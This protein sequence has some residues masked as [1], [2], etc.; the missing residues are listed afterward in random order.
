MF[1]KQGEGVGA[2]VMEKFSVF[3]NAELLKRPL[4]DIMSYMGKDLVELKM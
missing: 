2:K 3:A 1:H 4:K